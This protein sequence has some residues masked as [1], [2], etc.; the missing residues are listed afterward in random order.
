MTVIR[1]GARPR[2]GP[3]PGPRL[4]LSATEAASGH[5]HGAA[6]AAATAS[7]R[8]ACAGPQAAEPAA[9]L[10]QRP[11]RAEERHPGRVRLT[12]MLRRRRRDRPDRAGARSR[13]ARLDHRPGPWAGAGTY[14]VEAR[15]ENAQK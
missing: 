14:P 10:S 11:R 7:A 9:A 15:E 3:D 6:G 8:A 13:A 12:G 2:A 1:P 5:G 4:R